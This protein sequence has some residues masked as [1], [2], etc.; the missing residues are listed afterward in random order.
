MPGGLDGGVIALLL[1]GL[2]EVG[3]GGQRHRLADRVFRHEVVARQLR[4][5]DRPDRADVPG[6][7]PGGVRHR[8]R[9]HRPPDLPGRRRQSG[10]I[11]EIRVGPATSAASSIVTCRPSRPSRSASR[12]CRR[13]CRLNVYSR[14]AP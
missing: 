8:R 9:G 1:E 5:P 10:R 14:V 6:R 11:D 3:G 2:H 13:P 4:L 12:T 7:G